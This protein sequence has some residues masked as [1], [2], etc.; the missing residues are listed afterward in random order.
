MSYAFV[1]VVGRGNNQVLTGSLVN[2]LG[3]VLRV[4]DG[5]YRFVESGLGAYSLGFFLEFAHFAK[6]ERLAEFGYKL[7]GR[8]MVMYAIAKPYLLKILLKCLE[9]L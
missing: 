9:L 6:K 4:E 3:A 8:V 5:L 2:T 7:V 1:K